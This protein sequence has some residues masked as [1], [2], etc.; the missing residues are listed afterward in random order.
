MLFRGERARA[1]FA[2]LAGHSVRPLESPVSGAFGLV[3]GLGAHALHTGSG[4][5]PVAEGGGGAITGALRGYLES[6]GGTVRTGVRVE[7][8]GDVGDA[9]AVVC[10]VSPRALVGI[11]GE[12][13]QAGNRRL[14]ERYAYG[15]GSFKV[16]WALSERIPWTAPGVPCGGDGARGRDDGGDC[17]E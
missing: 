7:R 6:L 2:G 9:D 8:M 14:M 11:A 3:L 10:D 12:R 1:L 5:W 17:A 15:P 4:G 16:D 13:M